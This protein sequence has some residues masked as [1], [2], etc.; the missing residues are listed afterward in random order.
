MQL[1]LKIGRQICQQRPVSVALFSLLALSTALASWLKSS[2]FHADYVYQLETVVGGDTHLHGLLAL[3]LTLALYRVLSA[4]S[5]NYKVVLITGA[6]VAFCC[7]I[8]EGIQAFSPLRT[9]SV[10]DIL[11]SLM[12]VTIASLINTLLAGLRQR[13]QRSSE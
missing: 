7:L 2:G 8:D 4:T 13:K 9:F 11:A 5:S 1:S 10:L 12:G 6:L 3:F